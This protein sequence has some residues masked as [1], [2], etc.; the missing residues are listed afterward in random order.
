MMKQQLAAD[1]AAALTWYRRLT[2]SS[3]CDKHI[4]GKTQ[5]TEY[6]TEHEALTAACGMK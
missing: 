2:A 5:D 1:A 3:A 6:S 4:G